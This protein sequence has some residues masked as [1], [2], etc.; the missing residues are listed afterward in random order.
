MSEI[1]EVDW[2][3]CDSVEQVPGKMGGA[4][5]IKGTRVR[6]QTI[7]ANHDAGLSLKD[8]AEN[9]PE[10]P[11]STIAGVIEFHHSYVPQSR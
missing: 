2:R 4:P 1:T 9:W 8:L 11:E 7:V 10:L 3:E 6:A 5:V